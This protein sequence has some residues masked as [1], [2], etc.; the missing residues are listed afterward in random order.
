MRFRLFILVVAIQA[1]LV[2]VIWGASVDLSAISTPETRSLFV[3][4]KH[5]HSFYG[6][7]GEKNSQVDVGGKYA[8][9]EGRDPTYSAGIG[10]SFFFPSG[11]NVDSDLQYYHSHTTFAGGTGLGYKALSLGDAV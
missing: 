2:G 5:L 8:H 3:S 11:I 10:S 6:I 7:N 4:G 1:F 9:I